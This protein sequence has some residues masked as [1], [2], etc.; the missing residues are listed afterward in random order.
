MIISLFKIS[1]LPFFVSISSEILSSFNTRDKDCA[2]TFKSIAICF[3]EIVSKFFHFPKDTL[4]ISSLNLMHF[5]IISF[6][7][8]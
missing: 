1:I 7:K 8:F 4:I 5:E 3:C 2:L 6:L